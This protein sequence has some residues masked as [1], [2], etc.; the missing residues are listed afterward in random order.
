MFEVVDIKQFIDY[1]SLNYP[2]DNLSA[3]LRSGSVKVVKED[4]KYKMVFK[5]QFFF[6]K[7]NERHES[8]NKLFK[9]VLAIDYNIEFILDSTGK[10]LTPIE[11]EVAEKN[12]KEEELARRKR[13]NE[14]RM[15]RQERYFSES[16]IPLIKR[17]EYQ[18]DTYKCSKEN[19]KALD[20]IQN[21][22][23]GFLTICGGTGIGKTH[24]AF[25]CGIYA[26][27]GDVSQSVIY[28]QAEDL[29]DT[30]RKSFNIPDYDN[31]W[32]DPK[33]KNYNNS[34][35]GIM[36]KLQDVDILIID[37][38]GTQKN[39]DWV[40][41]KLDTIIDYRYVNE[42]NTIITTNLSMKSIKEI[43]ERIASRLSSGTVVT[44]VGQDYRLTHKQKIA[45]SIKPLEDDRME[46]MTS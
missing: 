7:L 13:Q 4:D 8:V 31:N 39:S 19:E 17:E 2:K 30:L 3:I 12:A 27:Y 40:L 36:R 22:C 37:D 15:Q 35:D 21:H 33:E 5:Q 18:F 23:N 41:S 25:S 42:K 6:E 29:L 26:I 34:Y 32:G 20:L 10:Y 44:L 43:S 9:L 14:I 1:T 28:Y 46:G 11:K 45:K 16:R 24:L 38:F